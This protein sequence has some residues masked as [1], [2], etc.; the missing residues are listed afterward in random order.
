M[1]GSLQLFQEGAPTLQCSKAENRLAAIF[2]K[3]GFDPLPPRKLAE[4]VNPTREARV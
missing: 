4:L 2:K 1:T 3:I